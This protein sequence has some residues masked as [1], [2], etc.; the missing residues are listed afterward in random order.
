MGTT[1]EIFTLLGVHIPFRSELTLTFILL[2]PSGQFY[3]IYCE[4]IHKI[5]H[6]KTLYLYSDTVCSLWSRR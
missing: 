3:T 6:N 2:V 1:L 4:F 5:F